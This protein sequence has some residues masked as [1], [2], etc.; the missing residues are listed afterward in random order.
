MKILMLTPYFPY[1]LT[2]GGQIRSYNL[3]KKLAKK[4]Q[5]TLF[6]FIR[7]EKETEFIKNLSPFCEKIAVFKRRR[8]WSPLN[9][10]LAAVTPRPFLLSIYYSPAFKKAISKE[11]SQGN[12]DLIHFECFYLMHNL[13]PTQV[14]IFLVEQT[15]EY[16]VYQN[17]VRDFPFWLLPLKPILYLDVLKIKLWEEHFWRR[18]DRLVTMSGE[19]KDFIQARLPEKKIDVIA[20]GVDIEFFEEVDRAPTKE[21]TVLFVGQFRWPPNIDAALFL[22][23]KIWPAIKEKVPQAKLWIIGRNPTPKILALAQDPEITV[24]EVEDIRQVLSQAWVLLAP[25]RNG[26]GTK[27]KV[28]EAM[29]SELPVVTTPLGIE[30][31]EAKEKM[32]VLVASSAETLAQA[33]VEVLSNSEQGRL[34][35]VKAKELVSRVYNWDSISKELDR[36][37]REV[38]SK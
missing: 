1:P 27:Y 33:T 30:G 12:Y 15:I 24:K 36:V 13:P 14:P 5:V 29:A 26:R 35:A 25:I 21:P 19:D 38:G 11:L 8:A 22:V 28:L 2:S 17:V 9:V 3:L 4:H 31:I 10:L 23:R 18:A 34:M 7:E 16:L 32:D 6:S 37:Y 20:N